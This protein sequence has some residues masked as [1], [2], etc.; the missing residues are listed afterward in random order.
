M[1]TIAE[2]KLPIG[3][4]QLFADAREAYRRGSAEKKFSREIDYAA[5]VQGFFRERLEFYLRD[6]LGFRH[7]VVK[8]GALSGKRG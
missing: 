7:D 5:A 6:V 3:L 2:H 4:T 8:R 1:K